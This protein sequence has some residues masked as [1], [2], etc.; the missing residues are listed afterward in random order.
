MPVE[1][2]AQLHQQNLLERIVFGYFTEILAYFFFPAASDQSMMAPGNVLDTTS[3]DL[4]SMRIRLKDKSFK[5]VALAQK[6]RESCSW[7]V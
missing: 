1:F 6:R 2:V 3:R 5:R 7:R 4:K